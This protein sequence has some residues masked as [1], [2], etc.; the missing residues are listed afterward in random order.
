MKLS[1]CDIEVREEMDV[2]NNNPRVAFDVARTEAV[3]ERRVDMCPFFGCLI[4]L[5]RESG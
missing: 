5:R 2:E 1:H 3:P 4:R